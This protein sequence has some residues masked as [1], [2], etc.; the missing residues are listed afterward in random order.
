MSKVHQTP[1]Q[2][3][4]PI[5]KLR[6]SVAHGTSGG[7]QN[8]SKRTA[9]FSPQDSVE[10]A[11]PSTAPLLRFLTMKEVSLRTWFQKSFLY[12]RI[13]GKTFLPS[14]KIGRSALFVESE[15]VSIQ[16]AWAIGSTPGQLRRFVAALISAR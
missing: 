10:S 16:R 13:R 15:I 11:P 4:R 6:P 14:I 7:A 12:L 2:H 8:L 3:N 1:V 9:V 5:A